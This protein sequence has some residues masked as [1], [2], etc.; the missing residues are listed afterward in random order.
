MTD[1]SKLRETPETDAVRIA[2]EFLSAPDIRAKL[3][4]QLCLQGLSLVADMI[5]EAVI[6]SS[7]LIKLERQRDE[8][9]EA[10]REMVL[11][12]D[13]ERLDP[14]NTRLVIRCDVAW[15]TARAALAKIEGER[16]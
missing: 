5:D 3:K 1:T 10:L 9:A 6:V 7:A 2:H 14:Y 11:I 13:T 15:K 4:V 16:K 12:R 8:L